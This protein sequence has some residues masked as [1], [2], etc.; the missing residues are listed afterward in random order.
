MLQQFQDATH[1][2]VWPRL[3]QIC[4][5]QMGSAWLERMNLLDDAT[6]GIA[7]GPHALGAPIQSQQRAAGQQPLIASSRLLRRNRL[8]A[9]P[10][11]G[12]YH[13]F[14]KRT[15]S[16]WQHPGYREDSSS[17]TSSF[18]RPSL[19]A[20][21]QHSPLLRGMRANSDA[22]YLLRL[23][24]GGGPGCCGAVRLPGTS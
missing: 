13:H 1:I 23:P 5:L 3:E 20:S 22:Q 21:R 7:R 4:L 18:C 19:A 14:L 24:L 9:R 12:N 11:A 6:Y 15:G 2:A 8:C 16:A 10:S 17:A